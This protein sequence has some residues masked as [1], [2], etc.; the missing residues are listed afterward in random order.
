MVYFVYYIE[1]LLGLFMKKNNLM[2]FVSF[3]TLFLLFG[4]CFDHADYSIYDGRYNNYENTLDY[5][6]PLF[7]LFVQ[8]CHFLKLDLQGFLQLSGLLLLVSLFELVRRLSVDRNKVISLYML[9]PLFFYDVVQVRNSLSLIFVYWA[10]LFIMSRDGDKKGTLL[11]VLFVVL[12]STVHFASIVFLIYLLAFKFNTKKCIGIALLIS[13][14]SFVLTQQVLSSLMGYV[15][16]GEKIDSVTTMA[17]ERY[18]GNNAILVNVAMLVLMTGTYF[19]LY[20]RNKKVSDKM[21]S[22]ILKFNVLSLCLIPLLFITVDFHR[23]FMAMMVF[24]FIVYAKWIKISKDKIFTM[25][26][27]IVFLVLFFYRSLAVSDNWERVYRSVMENNL[28]FD[29]SSYM[30]SYNDIMQDVGIEMGGV[31]C[32][33]AIILTHL[34]IKIHAAG[35]SA[36]ITQRR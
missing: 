16:L 29:N 26:S 19:L 5:T 14:S 31:I 3:V 11:F 7:I 18:H 2:Y 33:T 36:L 24:N 13:V 1:S 34:Y 22:M 27:L 21:D 15:V 23:T 35:N 30:V 12:A 28:I 17:S 4:W 10:F 9:S 32:V 20:W 25:C 6:E 8:L